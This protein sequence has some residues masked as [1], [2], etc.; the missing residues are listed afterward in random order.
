MQGNTWNS[1]GSRL[2]RAMRAGALLLVPLAL[3]CGQPE[4]IAD[5]RTDPATLSTTSLSTARPAETTTPTLGQAVNTLTTEVRSGEIGF[6]E[7]PVDR[8]ML[9]ADAPK[10]AD[11]VTDITAGK[12]GGRLIKAIAGD[13]RTFNP[14]YSQSIDD[15]EAAALMFGGLTGYDPYHQKEGA[16]MAKSWDYKADTQE[17]IFH[18]REGL[19]W[20]DGVPLTSD[21]FLFYTQLVF[22]PNIP[23]PKRFSFTLEGTEASAAYEFSA[24]DPLTFVA[25]IPGVDSFAILN[26]GLLRA[27]PRH[28]LGKLWEEGKL[29]EA[30]W[31]QNVNPKEIVACG[32]FVLSEVRPGQAYIFKPNPHYWRF[33]SK[34]QRLPYIDELMLR[35]VGDQNAM[36]LT[37]MNNEVDFIERIKPDVLGTML[38]RQE[39]K[40]YTVYS[41]GPSLNINH[42]YFNLSQGG[43]YTKEDGT[44]AKWQPSRPGETAPEGLK[45]Y[46]PFIDPVKR[47]WFENVEFRRACSEAVNRDLIIQNVLFGEGVALYGAE[48]P[49]D[50]VWFNPHK[51]TYPY[52]PEQAKARLEASGFSDRDGD[53]VREDAQGNPLRFTLITN[54]EN[55]I[56]ERVGQMIAA[57]LKE[58]GIDCKAQVL[59]FQQIITNLKDDYS[60]EA[61]LLGLG[62]GVPPHPAM[63][64]NVW[65]SS[66]ETHWGNP[67]QKSPMTEWEAKID[68]LYNGMKKV[69]KLEEQVALYGQILEIY[70]EMLPQIPLYLTKDYVA[71]SNKIGNLKPTVIGCSVT[72]NLDELYI[73]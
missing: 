71:A 4:D 64:R 68:S 5:S 1:W 3:A 57:D 18:L 11:V 59:D 34:G 2:R 28:A 22:D 43:S 42:F 29:T 37:F 60:Y 19:K 63:G 30:T 12:H 40:G 47:A 70:S 41:L 52:N 6:P 61:V 27:M 17:W 72:H 44:S 8:S 50:T 62:S 38:D 16:G 26:L 45:G 20:S 51:Q 55:N 66:G 69:F 65:L 21:D 31:S 13:P 48:S 25:K 73:K 39:Q 35:V 54:R 36:A 14:L 10:D 49:A 15:Q 7:Q 67:E 46:K 56:R 33:D 9:P 58:I 53:G 32:P 23:N 24:P